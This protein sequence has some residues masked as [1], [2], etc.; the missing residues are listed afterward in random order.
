MKHLP[1]FLAML[2]L[3]AL[4]SVAQ[5]HEELLARDSRRTIYEGVYRMC[6]VWYRHPRISE[7]QELDRSHLRVTYEALVVVDTLSGMAYKDRMIVLV[8]DKLYKSYGEGLWKTNM[9]VSSEISDNSPQREKYSKGEGYVEALPHAVYRDLKNKAITNRA[10]FPEIKNTFFRYDEPQPKFRW[11][12]T[13]EM[14]EI[15]GYSC[16]KARTEY[17]GREWTVWF[18][19][20]IPVDC[21]L[22]KFSGLPGLILEAHDS[23]NEYVFTLNGI[24]QKEEPIEWYKTQKERKLSRET[25]R[26]QEQNLYDNPLFYGQGADGYKMIIDESRGLTGREIFTPDHFLYPYNPMELE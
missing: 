22:W 14:T 1:I 23:K 24:E 2:S 15:K 18:T 12:L 13:G 25:F 26:K 9:L 6:P 17:H 16:Q 11:T 8:G 4:T 21:G 19:P 5:T 10:V 20:E 7:V 3:S